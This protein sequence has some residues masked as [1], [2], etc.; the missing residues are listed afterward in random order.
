MEHLFHYSII[1]FPF[2]ASFVLWF[3]NKIFLEKR[4]TCLTVL[5]ALIIS[6]SFVSPVLAH[7]VVK[8][9]QAG[10]ATFQTFTVGVPNEKENPVVALRLVIPDGLKSVSPN[11]KSGWKIEIKKSGGGEDAKV[12]EIDWTGGSIP[13]GQRDEFLFS[14]QVPAG[15]TTLKWRAYQT[16]QNGDVV[17]W[18]Q[19]PSVMKDMSDDDKEE[20]EKTGKGPYSETKVINDLKGEKDAGF[21]SNSEGKGNLLEIKI[22]LVA[23]ILSV[24]AIALS[25]RKRS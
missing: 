17:S 7:V 25:M 10:V 15:E 4:R 22:S 2:I 18:D 23:L 20:M 9:N 12:T 3:K 1:G 13:E 21:S 8:P 19:D 5:I 11:V 14:A 6:F 24:V 16:Y